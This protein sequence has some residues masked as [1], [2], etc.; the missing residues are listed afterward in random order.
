MVKISKELRCKIRNA[1][2]L[3][4][5]DV[6]EFGGASYG[7]WQARRN[8]A[9]YALHKQP[10]M[11]AGLFWEIACHLPE[12]SV[13]EQD[14]LLDAYRHDSREFFAL[15]VLATGWIWNY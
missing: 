15:A 8:L 9:S 6:P 12:L 11:A 2:L 14:A 3:W 1:A 7:R 4:M 5:Q 10:K 13:E